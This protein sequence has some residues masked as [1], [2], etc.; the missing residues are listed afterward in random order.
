MVKIRLKRG[1]AKKRPHY[2]VIAIDERVQRDGR[3]LEY[4]GHY[5]PIRE[6]AAIQLEHERIAH[7]VGQGAQLSH[8]VKALLRRARRRAAAAPPE[9]PAPPEEAPAPAQAEPVQAELAEAAAAPAPAAE[10]GES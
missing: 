4:L 10:G 8:A 9:P 3:A 2:R 7:W 5:D 6:P 1:G